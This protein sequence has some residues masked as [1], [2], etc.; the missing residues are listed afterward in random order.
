MLIFQYGS[1]I[2]TARL[3]DR[4]RLNGD[5]RVISIVSTVDKFDI[6]FTVWS[7]SNGCAA[8][9]IVQSDTGRHIYGV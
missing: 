2:S 5:A 9:D 7:K 3:N 6:A 4:D 8:A 1:N